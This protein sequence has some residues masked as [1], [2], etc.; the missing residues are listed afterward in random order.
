M[1]LPPLW[2]LPPSPPLFPAFLVLSVPLLLG[3]PL[4]LFHLLPINPH[5][6]FQD[7][8]SDTAE[9]GTEG[10][11]TILMAVAGF[12]ADVTAE[13]GACEASS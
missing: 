4:L 8:G 13:E 7:V 5:S 6:V 11:R 12:A 3:F 9:Y 1:P 10:G 2:R